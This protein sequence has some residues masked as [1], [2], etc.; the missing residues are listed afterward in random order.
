MEVPQPLDINSSLYR[1]SLSPLR[2]PGGKGILA[3][4]V[5]TLI[6]IEGHTTRYVEPFAGGAGVAVDLLLNTELET[7]HI[8]DLDPAVYSFW[9][10]I[11]NS[12][13]EIMKFIQDI[14]VSVDEWKKMKFQYNELYSAGEVSIDLAKVFFFLNRTCYSG[15]MDGGVIGGFQQSGKTK[16]GDRFNKKSLLAKIEAITS[17]SDRLEVSNLNASVLLTNLKDDRTTFVYLDPPYVEKGPSLYFRKFDSSSHRCLAE[18]LAKMGELSWILSYDNVS[19]IRVLY[20]AFKQEVF[21]LRYSA[22]HSRMGSEIM[23][24]SDTVWTAL[25]RSNEGMTVSPT[26]P[27]RNC[28]KIY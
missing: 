12:P 2:Y 8:N 16:I 10:A 13:E 21:D 11:K 7:I 24:F 23:V 19:D 22:R 15:I 26:E 28:T 17:A 4:Y 1:R 3:R 18:Q 5:R 25:N 20:G 27:K 9:L 14:E 6:G